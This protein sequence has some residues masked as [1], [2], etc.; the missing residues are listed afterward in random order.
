[1]NAR[2]VVIIRFDDTGEHRV[3]GPSGTEAE[4][5]Y[6]DDRQD[7]ID[8]ARE[9]LGVAVEDIRFKHCEYCDPDAEGTA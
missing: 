3:P 4:A 1:M 9:A 6:T 2:R 8:T 7:A 5:Y